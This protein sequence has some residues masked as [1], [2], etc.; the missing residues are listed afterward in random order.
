MKNTLAFLVE[1]K[2]MEKKKRKK[3]YIV[4]WNQ[5][6][7]SGFI[8]QFQKESLCF[9]LLMYVLVVFKYFF[10]S[11]CLVFGE[12]KR[13]T[14]SA[15]EKLSFVDCFMGPGSTN[16]RLPRLIEWTGVWTTDGGGYWSSVSFRRGP[17]NITLFMINCLWDSSAHEINGLMGRV[18]SF[19]GRQGKDPIK[20]STFSPRQWAT[21][22]L[23]IRIEHCILAYDT[24]FLGYFPHHKNE[25]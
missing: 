24:K 5:H 18:V 15:W 6:W 20:L 25:T 7:E 14:S 8:M 16:F 3:D 10:M 9:S 12:M 11:I 21:A 23:G 13:R 2:R 22:Q 19:I 4:C 1:I 17:T